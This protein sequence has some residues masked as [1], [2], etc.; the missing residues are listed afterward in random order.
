MEEFCARGLRE[1][2][3]TQL[4]QTTTW[5][6]AR[7]PGRNASLKHRQRTTQQRD[8]LA[9]A[10]WASGIRHVKD[11]RNRHRGRSASQSV[12]VCVRPAE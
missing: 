4:A 1:D 5:Q 10:A 9:T 8:H 3:K 7:A 12:C 11:T 6:A 2:N